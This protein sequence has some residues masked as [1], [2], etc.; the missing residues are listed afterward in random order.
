MNPKKANWLF[1]S[2]LGFEAVV[3]IALIFCADRWKIGILGSL[4]VSQ[5]IILIPTLLFLLLTRTDPF[6]LIQH[7]RLRVSTVFMIIGFSFLMMPLI[8][9]VNMISLLFVENTVTNMMQ[10]VVNAPA[11]F[12]I[13]L[14]AVAGPA[15][16]E[17]VFRGVLYHSYKKSGRFVGAMLLSAFL[18]GLTHMNF[19]QMSYAILVGI[20]C[21]LLVECT[22]S[23]FASMI[24]HM[25]INLSNVIPVFLNPEAY[26]D[27]GKT[28]ELELGRLGMTYQEYLYMEIGI[29]GVIAL[30]TTSLAICLL[31]AIARQ[32][33]RSGYVA[34][35]FHR[36]EG[37]ERERLISMPLV[38]SVLICFGVMIYDIVKN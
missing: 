38:L 15:S 6:T 8:L 25:M 22:G 21:V 30:I 29:F 27:T 36:K 31:Y 4:T 19:N 24:F 16:E 12:S 18:F 26:E 34:A 20:V 5:L 10:Y 1:L 32:E 11:F 28:L 23:I 37:C 9:V 14:I 13:L 3:M 35:L 17:I 33:G 2:T 7:N